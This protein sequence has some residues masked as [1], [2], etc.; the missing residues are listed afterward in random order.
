VPKCQSNFK[1][2][3]ITIGDEGACLGPRLEKWTSA[4]RWS[5]NYWRT[6]GRA[7]VCLFGYFSPFPD[8][9]FRRRL[10]RSRPMSHFQDRRRKSHFTLTTI[11]Q[12]CVDITKYR[13]T[14]SIP[15]FTVGH[16]RR[17]VYT[18]R[19]PFL[20]RA[21]TYMDV[22]KEAV[23]RHPQHLCATTWVHRFVSLKNHYR[24]DVL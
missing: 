3:W 12:W 19:Q 24:V 11:D 16:L 9:I 20:A 2:E 13:V 23:R 14:H 4:D 6:K 17:S 18:W 5:T 21:I 10:G 8:S 7:V 15:T 1:A 22:R